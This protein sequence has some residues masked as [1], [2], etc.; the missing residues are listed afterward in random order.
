MKF[1]AVETACL[2]PYE[3]LA[4]EELLMKFAQPGI[5][6]LFLWQNDHTIVIGRNQRLEA[7]CHVESFLKAGGWIARRRSGGGAVYHDRGNLNYSFIGYEAEK[8]RFC[9]VDIIGRAM[10]SLGLD[11][12]FNGRNDLLTGQ[13]KFSGTASYRHKSVVCTHGTILI[14]GDT[15]AMQ[16]YLTPE[17]SKMA[18]NGVQSVAARVVNLCSLLPTLTVA[19]VKKAIMQVTESE[20]LPWRV[21]Q[22]ELQKLRTVYASK[23]WIFGGIR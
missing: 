10:E 4:Y 7:E 2:N 3:N 6:I 20:A 12:P 5:C 11:V 16:R 21:N 15:S 17:Q 23:E 18:R 19:D 8:D 1:Y 9:Y 22:D 14:A 13:R